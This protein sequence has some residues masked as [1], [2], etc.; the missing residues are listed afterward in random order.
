M[1]RRIVPWTGAGLVLLGLASAVVLGLTVPRS[2]L[3]PLG[4]VPIVIGAALLLVGASRA[5]D[6]RAGHAAHA[7]HAAAAD[8]P[9]DATTSLQSDART[10]RRPRVLLA[11]LS[12]GVGIATVVAAVVAVVPVVVTSV[13]DGQ[14]LAVGL[15]DIG[16]DGNPAPDDSATSDPTTAPDPSGIP[17]H[18]VLDGG[19][20]VA[21]NCGVALGGGPDEQCWSWTFTAPQACTAKVTI[22]FGDAAAAEPDHTIT[23]F[24]SLSPDVPLSLAVHGT[25]ATAGIVDTACVRGGDAPQPSTVDYPDRELPDGDFPAACD[26]WGC[27]GFVFET[28]MDCP[29]AT[30]QVA[31]DDDVD[32][33]LSR[34]YAIVEEVRS[35]SFEAPNEVFVPWRDGEQPV[36]DEITSVTCED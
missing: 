6:A 9:A 19:D 31:V 18:Q 35:S 36:S 8:L 26:D 23:R 17:I 14:T 5:L 34:A 15:Q 2:A 3:A 33:H 21:M 13:G 12:T 27:D 24:V 29:A 32:G 30:V 4:L 1:M 7:G 11:A 28:W 25:G 22:G 16:P 10:S 20:T